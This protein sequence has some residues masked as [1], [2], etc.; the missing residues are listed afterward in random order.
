[1]QVFK[2]DTV[3]YLADTTNG[4]VK[5]TTTNS[6]SLAG[7][8]ASVYT[9]KV[10]TKGAHGLAG[11][12]E[13]GAYVLYCTTFV[14]SANGLYRYDTSTEGSGGTTVGTMS[15]LATA[16][17]STQVSRRGGQ[18]ASWVTSASADG[19]V[20]ELPRGIVAALVLVLVL[21]LAPSMLR[22]PRPAVSV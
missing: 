9:S 10:A 5:Y 16:A 3:M 1:M 7:P 11:R 13:G 19:A 15:L 17:A 14:T 22:T 2:S 8:W 21:V 18:G 6:A 20:A 12:F 4:I